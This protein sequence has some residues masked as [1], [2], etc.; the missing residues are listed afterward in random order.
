[1]RQ[2]SLVICV[3]IFFFVPS[4]LVLLHVY[5]LLGATFVYFFIV[6][7]IFPV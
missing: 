5:Y 7:N 2:L 4:I 6:S 1:M 3:S